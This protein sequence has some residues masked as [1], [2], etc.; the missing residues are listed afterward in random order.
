M[1]PKNQGGLWG[2]LWSLVGPIEVRQIGWFSICTGEQPSLQVCL[3]A[4]GAHKK[5]AKI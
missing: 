1:G 5:I 4:Y 3:R 2:P